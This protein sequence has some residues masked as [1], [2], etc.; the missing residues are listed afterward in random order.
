M[1]LRE[2]GKAA[3]SRQT[4]S[5]SSSMYRA[6]AVNGYFEGAQSERESST[7]DKEMT[8]IEREALGKD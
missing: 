1:G 8:A 5:G 3:K 6:M 4:K 2:K 7:R